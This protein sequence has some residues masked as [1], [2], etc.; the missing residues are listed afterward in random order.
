MANV[1]HETGTVASGDVTLFYRLFGKAGATPIIIFHGANY[2]D[3]AD[4][5]EVA[6]ALAS[7]RQVLAWDTR[8]FGKSTWSASK[9]YSLDTQM[10]DVNALLDHLGWN[11]VIAMGHSMGGG[12]S[13]LF[14]ARFP[15]R[16]E[17]LIIVDH[18]PGKG[19]GVAAAAKQSI[20]N[21]ATRYESVE[22][23]QKSMSRHPVA[24][25][26]PAE[27]RLKEILLPADGGGFTVARDPDYMNPVPV[28]GEGRTPKIVV[29]DMWDELAT[30]KCPIVIV[31]G[32][33]SDRYTPEAIARVKNDY[34]HIKMVDV[35]SGH[36]VAG[37]A[38]GPLIDAARSF[39][40]A[41]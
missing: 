14:S 1:Q 6:G 37:G 31:R 3:S 8:G 10:A 18:C 5:I 23:A 27:A 21:A 28:G 40:A 25:G 15:Q 17:K 29:D 34:P 26:T 33:Q 12:R 19:G 30:V 36:D 2:Y 20:G 13:I 32:T 4:W 16:V 9:D 39:L 24:A 22:A 11:K 38:P 35:E 7:D 41:S